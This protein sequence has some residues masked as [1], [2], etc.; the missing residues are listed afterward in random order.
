VNNKALLIGI[1]VGVFFAGLGIGY[2]IFGAPVQQQL[3][4]QQ[5]Q[6]TSLQAEVASLKGTTGTQ[7]F[8]SMLGL[9]GSSASFMQGAGMMQQG[10]NMM[11]QAQDI[12]AQDRTQGNAMM[13]L[14]SN[15]MQ[16][17]FDMMQQASGKMQ[18]AQSQMPPFSG[19]MMQ[20]FN[21][22]MQSRQNMMDAA[23]TMMQARQTMM[24]MQQQGMM[25]G[26]MM[27]QQNI[28]M[29]MQGINNMSQGMA[30][31]QKYMANMQQAQGMM[32]MQPMMGAGGFGFMG[33]MM[34]SPT[35]GQGMMQGPMMGPGMMGPMMGSGMM[36]MPGMGAMM[37]NQTFGWG[38]MGMMNVQTVQPLTVGNV[39]KAA[40]DFV[41]SLNNP[42]L[43]IKDIME[44]ERNFY[45]IV[46]EKDTSIGAF[47]M[48]VWKDA[49]GMMVA[50]TMHPEP[51]PNMMWN[52]KYSMMPFAQQTTEMTVS[53]DKAGSLA[54][55]YLDVNFPG[56][57]VED[58]DRFYGY[59]TVHTEK[60]GKISGMLSVNGLT[61]QIWYHSWH[62]QFIQELED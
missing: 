20:G 31:M 40:E 43:A 14:G 3:Q 33:P 1:A 27:G 48:L 32:G 15:M 35:W 52:T 45:F 58:V 59:Y 18:Q 29:M 47:E 25:Q 16:Q 21:S 53:K 56:T 8:E 39:K 11:L 44:F 46:Y 2:A 9:T 57:T 10:A 28:P 4:N 30:Q 50:G 38:P 60:D 34:M 7:N 26:P 6:I 37:W 17:G 42:N 22:M 49:A 5:N 19:S 23:N 13:D 55:A 51:G 61:G 54:K 41:K 62:G 36:G 12:M 24:N